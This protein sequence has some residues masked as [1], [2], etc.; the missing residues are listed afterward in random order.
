MMHTF[1]FIFVSVAFIAS[2]ELVK[3]K[4]R[5]SSDVTRRVTH[6]GAAL[7]AALAP[8]FIGQQAIIIA[9]LFFAGAL[10]LAR[11]SAVFSSI[12]DVKRTTFGDV[13]LPLGEAISAVIFLPHAVLAFQFGALV[14]GISDAVAG[15][16]GERFG[17]HHV[18]FFSNTKSLE[19]S[20]AFFASTLIL[21]LLFVPAFSYQIILIATILTLVE[22]VLIYG[23]DN[24]VLPI[25]GSILI[26]MIL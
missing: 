10:L 25:I 26:Q 8:L 13:Y 15:L 14:M 24:L 17:R 2:V 23:L 1:L 19:A 22:F 18:T 21:V 7:I 5:L 6:I 16:V 3:R 12:H 9:C 4:S 11:R 20:L